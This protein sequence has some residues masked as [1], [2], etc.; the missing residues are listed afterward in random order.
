MF[1]VAKIFHGSVSR[2]PRHAC[3]V[4]QNMSEGYLVLTVGGKLWPCVGH[5][6]PVIHH[7]HGVVRGYHLIGR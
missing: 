3:G 1:P 5:L 7:C 4:E 6:Y 2:K